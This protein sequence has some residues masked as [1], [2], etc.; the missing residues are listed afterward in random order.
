MVVYQLRL[1]W[2]APKRTSWL[3]GYS[4]ITTAAIPNHVIDGEFAL[5]EELELLD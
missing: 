3:P 4:D 2:P 5:V 1:R